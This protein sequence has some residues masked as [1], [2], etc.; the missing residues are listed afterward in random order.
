[1][2]KLEST[3]FDMT[4]FVRKS[5]RGCYYQWNRQGRR[6]GSFKACRSVTYCLDVF[7]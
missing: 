5:V 6:F 2:C 7:K 1:M 4:A 3:P